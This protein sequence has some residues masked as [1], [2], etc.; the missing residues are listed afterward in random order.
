MLK[1]KVSREVDLKDK[2]NER[3]R[4]YNYKASK[5]PIMSKT[6]THTVHI[7]TSSTDFG[8]HFWLSWLGCA[9]KAWLDGLQRNHRDPS[10]LSGILYFDIGSIFH[11]L[12]A[13]HYSLEPDKAMAIDTNRLQYKTEGGPLDTEKYEEAI[14]EAERLYRAYRAFWGPRDFGKIVAVEEEIEA[15]APRKLT[16]G[17]DLIC[18]LNKRDLKRLNFDSEPGLYPVDTKTRSNKDPMEYELALHDSQFS[19]YAKLVEDKYSESVKGFIV[20]LAYKS[21]RPTFERFVVPRMALAAEW[22]RTNDMLRIAG[23]RH[24]QALGALAEGSLPEVNI[25]ECFR[26]SRIGWDICQ[27]YKNNQ[28]DRKQRGVIR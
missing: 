18:R 15:A 8:P 26:R 11:G 3:R 28:C 6:K 21:L 20:D 17:I 27:H 1:E 4:L 25:R 19:T 9:R 2:E 7:R 24:G 23:A 14:R 16:G 5:E 13:L 12:K 10:L 22:E